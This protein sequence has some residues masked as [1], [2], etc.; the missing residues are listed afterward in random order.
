MPQQLS[1]P[2]RHALS[3]VHLF[4]Q[5]RVGP[6]T[7]PQAPLLT[8]SLPPPLRSAPTLTAR[9]TL[10]TATNRSGPHCTRLALFTRPSPQA[11]T[12]PA[13][14]SRHVSAAPVLPSRLHFL[15]LT[16]RR[17]INESQ[18]RSHSCCIASRRS[19]CRS[20]ERGGVR[21]R[22]SLCSEPCQRCWARRA[23]HDSRASYNVA[24]ASRPAIT[25]PTA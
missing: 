9:H 12:V 11:P 25:Q 19:S 18:C 22:S 1:S 3:L 24:A 20:L 13:L 6:E 4:V 14:P 7:R 2:T 16:R 21:L 15:T 5:L 17:T 23:L 10:A 8:L